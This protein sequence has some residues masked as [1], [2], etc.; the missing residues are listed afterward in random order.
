MIRDEKKKKNP[1]CSLST[2]GGQYRRLAYRTV[3]TTN[4]GPQS[5]HFSNLFIYFFFFYFVKKNNVHK[6]EKEKRNVFNLKQ[7]NY[8]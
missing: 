3:V 4:S 6:K 2:S 1:N 5:L 7:T 8:D